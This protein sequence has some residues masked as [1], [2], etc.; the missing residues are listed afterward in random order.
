[1]HLQSLCARE[2][3]ENCEELRDSKLVAYL[4]SVETGFS[5]SKEGIHGHC[6]VL[7]GAPTA[8]SRKGLFKGSM[9][10]DKTEGRSRVYIHARKCL[11]PWHKIASQRQSLGQW[12]TSSQ[13]PAEWRKMMISDSEEEGT[14]S[15]S[16]WEWVSA[17][18]HGRRNRERHKGMREV[19][20]NTASLNRQD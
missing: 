6:V 11:S 17:G 2:C 19:R 18:I 8:P 7:G 20:E 12:S 16:P 3:S 13:L 10:K 4:F 5:E 14:A 9:A 15:K 1:M